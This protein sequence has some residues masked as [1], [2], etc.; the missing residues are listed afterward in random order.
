[1]IDIAHMICMN[2]ACVCERERE[3]VYG[4]L[5]Y[6]DTS[7]AIFVIKVYGI[8]TYMDTSSAI[9]VIKLVL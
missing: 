7:S 6:M 5:T 8:L 1:M 9:F 2:T 3:R 4:I